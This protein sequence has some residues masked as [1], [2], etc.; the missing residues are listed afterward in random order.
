MLDE[1]LS[2]LLEN[3]KAVYHHKCT[4]KFDDFKLQRAQKRF[5]KSKENIEKD[6]FTS[7]PVKRRSMSKDATQTK[8]FC[9]FCKLADEDQ[10]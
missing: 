5:N 8:K 1:D 7:L 10:S 6:A 4:N 2:E 3:R 9:C